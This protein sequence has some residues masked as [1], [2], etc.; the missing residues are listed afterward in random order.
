MSPSERGPDEDPM[1]QEKEMMSLSAEEWQLLL[2]EADN[3]EGAWASP[4][5]NALLWARFRSWL[6]DSPKNQEDFSRLQRAFGVFETNDV[7]AYVAARS[8]T[9]RRHVAFFRV[10]ASVA[11]AAVLVF[12]VASINL[13]PSSVVDPKYIKTAIGDVR[14]V[15]LEDASTVYLDTDSEIE[16]SFSDTERR[17]SLL[18][19]QAFFDVAHGDQRIFVVH[20]PYATVTATGT[21]FEVDGTA[22][23]GEISVTLFS[24]GVDVQAVSSP[25]LSERLQFWTEKH[26]PNKL[27]LTP[28]QSVAVK[29]EGEISDIVTIALDDGD[30]AEWRFE[31]LSLDNVRLEDA[32]RLMNRYSVKRIVIRGQELADLEVSGVFSTGSPES[33]AH[34]VELLLPVNVVDTG[35]SILIQPAPV[36]N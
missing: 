2:S 9:I 3:G 32:V 31:E 7:P 16:V 28:G 30:H 4:E 34:A 35:Q 29:A 24:G 18:S 20:T 6:N 36:Q 1:Q 15:R 25:S 14:S 23:S 8:N 33:F 27:S 13:T 26:S 21:S 19:G 11:A 22:D 5:R 17:I 12:F 10:A